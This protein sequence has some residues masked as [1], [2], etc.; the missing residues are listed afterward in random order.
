MVM[1]IVVKVFGEFLLKIKVKVKRNVVVF[2]ECC[3][4]V[5]I[6]LC[7]CDVLFVVEVLFVF[8]F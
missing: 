1:Y 5:F 7:L 8:C 6:Y 4:E 3:V 2:D